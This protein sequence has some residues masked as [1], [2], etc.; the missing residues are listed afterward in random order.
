M[1][2]SDILKDYVKQKKEIDDLNDVIKEKKNKL[3]ETKN[4]ILQYMEKKSVPELKYNDN[5]F[6]VKNN[7]TYSSFTQKYLKDTIKNYFDNNQD[8]ISVDELIKFIL[9]NRQET[10]QTDLHLSLNK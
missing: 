6:S 2:L 8:N 1:K 4:T 7:K 5:K 9:T 3:V 10:T